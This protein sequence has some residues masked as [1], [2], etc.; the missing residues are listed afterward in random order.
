M[1]SAARHQTYYRLSSQLAQLD[2]EA[3]RL[4]LENTA[5]K[6][7]WG[8]TDT[9]TVDG[10]TIFVKRLPVTP[11]EYAHQF[12][13]QNHYDLPTYY[14][15]GIWSGGFGVFRELVTH[16]KTTNWVLSGAT[17]QF[18]LL[19]HYR[20]MPWPRTQGDFTEEALQSYVAYW[21][22]NRQIE[23]YIRERDSAS[24][25]LLL[26]L[27]Y[28][29]HSVETWLIDHPDQL[30]KTFSQMQKAV[31]FLNQQGIL[32]FDCDYNNAV[33]D[34][35]LICLTDFGLVIDQSYALSDDERRFFEDHR[36]YD[37]ALLCGATGWYFFMHYRQVAESQQAEVAKLCAITDDMKFGEVSARLIANIELLF[38]HGYLGLD[39]ETVALVVKHRPV[40]LW[41]LHFLNELRQSATK[42]LPFDQTTLRGLLNDVK[43]A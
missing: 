21:G 24:H 13:T 11:V 2:N 8:K 22:G 39:E 32:H 4:R 26:F 40:I 38:A 3:L 7:G 12:S 28:F 25:Q 36:E 6:P 43:T 23:T 29:P 42:E 14:H 18:P 1:T 31:T 15:Y 37:T 20:I 27:E 34:G 17:E 41:M 5:E 33:T 35:S 30:G 19:Y 10:T 16:I 9:I